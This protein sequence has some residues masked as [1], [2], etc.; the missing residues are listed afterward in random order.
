MSI[1]ARLFLD[2]CFADTAK[3]NVGIHITF[4]PILLLTGFLFVRL[5][6]ILS[7]EALH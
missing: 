5:L 6:D 4:V 7:L 3:V 1:N 2:K